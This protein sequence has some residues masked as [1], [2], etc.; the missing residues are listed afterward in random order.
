MTIREVENTW[1][2]LLDG[3]RLAAR[4]WLPADAQAQPVPAILEYLPYRKDD[5]TSSQDATRHPYFARHGYAAVRVD[6]RGTGDSD[7]I[8]TDEYTSQELDD[9]LEV[10]AW[11]EAQPWC[12]G[13]VGMIGYSWGGFNGLQ[14]AAR[15]PEQLK[16]VVTAYA[17]DD[18]YTDDCHYMGGCLLGSDM[19]KW[20]TSMRVYNALPPDPRFRDDWQ[21]VWM[22]R[23]EKT[24]PFVEAWTSH[25][26]RDAYWK[27]GSVAEDYSAIRVPTLV[28]G[29]WADAYTNAVPRLIEHLTCER[30]GIIGP[31]AHI[32]PYGGVPGPAIGF[33]AECVRWFDRWLK[34]VDTGVEGDPLL[35]AWIQESVPPAAWYAERPGRWVGVDSWPAQDAHGVRFALGTGSI[36]V[37]APQHTG[38]T[39]GVW[40]ANGY[41]DE[42]AEDQTPDDAL[43]TCFDFAALTEPL[44][45]LGH[46]IAT[47]SL[48]SD[49]PLA[50]VAVRLCEVAAD[51]AST[52]V[53]WGLLNLAHRDG[54]EHPA[55]LEVGRRYEVEV[56]LNVIG[57]RFSAG[58]RL[59]LAVSQAYWP[60]AWP[61][62]EPTQLT[63]YADA[64][65]LALPV[66]DGA[67]LELER[68]FAEPENCGGTVKLRE[69]TRSRT[70]SNDTAAGRHV[71]CDVQDATAE[72]LSGTVSGAH[73]ED[74]YV[75]GETDPLSARVEA[76]REE[77]L[78]RPGWR[79]RVLCEATMTA[80]R[81]EFIVDDELS[82]WDGDEL[83]F[84]SR[85]E[86]RV[87]RGCV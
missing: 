52:L 77:S 23:L 57:H 42:L 12:S 49:R 40:C 4:L 18:R 27:H 28:V 38:E 41:E 60:H 31:W 51:G 17:A 59:R 7:G 16:A 1:I 5:G 33:L 19:L 8:I 70:R 65:D 61:S 78:S 45:V 43:S 64:S 14:V 36:A 2:P 72:L 79:V 25:Q 11:I 21:E 56:P 13:G 86:I 47:L 75:I 84:Q 34:G 76:R 3:T 69:G 32:L 30:R 62:P 68:P 9:A 53:S 15:A 6:I 10:L 24:P 35:R 46:P 83:V 82:A 81:D 39:A 50:L 22:E 29:G 80:T 85:R 55:A 54:H 58:S 67:A 73:A 44:E 20:A 26:R 71:I 48:S 74:V 37:S 63:L 87:P 66:L